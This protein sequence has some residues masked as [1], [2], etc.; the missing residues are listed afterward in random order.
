VISFDKKKKAKKTV[1]K[2]I[3]YFIQPKRKQLQLK[4]Q[5]K[6]SIMKKDTFNSWREPLNFSIK[7]ILN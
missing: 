4:L 6:L 3:F 7:I 5:S 2:G 1:D